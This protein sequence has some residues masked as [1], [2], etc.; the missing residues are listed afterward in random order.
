MAMDEKPECLGFSFRQEQLLGDVQR[1][2][3]AD[4]AVVF[5][6]AFAQVVN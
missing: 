5:G 3:G 4:L 6:K 2:T 1:D